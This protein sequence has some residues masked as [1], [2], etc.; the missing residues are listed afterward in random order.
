MASFKEALRR[1][2]HEMVKGRSRV[3][4]QSAVTV[5]ETEPPIFLLGTYGSGTTLLR[6]VVDSHSRIC[7][8][9]ES[10]FMTALAPILSDPTYRQGLDA[11]GFDEAHVTQELR[12]FCVHFFANYARSWNKP[13]WADKTPGYV[14]H[15]DFLK[16]LFPE[17][18]FVIIHRH[19][20]DQAHSFTRGGTFERPVLEPFA[21]AD[22]DLRLACCRFWL[23]KTQRLLDFEARY[24]TSCYRLRYEDLCAA[25]EE[26]LRP[27]FAFL[28]EAWE[29]QVLKFYEQRHDKG[30][31][32]GRVV[33]TRG[34]EARSG[35]YRSWPESLRDA[36]LAIAA[37]SLDV[38]G[39]VEDAEPA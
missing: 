28:D 9:P 12:R 20:L 3:R 35:H 27:L 34:F 23:D 25:P 6:Y 21:R 14:D 19:G 1:I 5:T 4:F 16:G 32:H 7:C 30:H 37:P 39:Y 17:A 38:L 13:R 22:E 36:G 15:A 11:M 8:P 29:P 18:R 24:P 10:D 31:E 26:Q 2:Y 33:A